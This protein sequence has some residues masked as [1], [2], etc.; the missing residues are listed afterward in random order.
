M[1]F[2]TRDF[3]KPQKQTLDS[4]PFANLAEEVQPVWQD[5]KARQLVIDSW[6]ETYGIKHKAWVYPQ[7]LA[8]VKDW[9]VV[10]NETGLI[11]AKNLL[12][13]SVKHN[14]EHQGIYCFLMSN[15]RYLTKQASVEGLPYCA[16]VPLILA[17]FK[18]YAAIPYSQWDRNEVSMVINPSLYEAATL[19]P[20]HFSREE[21]LE[22]RAEG[23]RVKTGP[24]A[25]TQR[26]PITT[27]GLHGLPWEL[28]DGRA[29]MGQLPQLTRMMLCQTW[30]AHPSLRNEYMI[31][32]PDN[33]DELPDPLVSEHW[34]V[35]HAKTYEKPDLPVMKLPWD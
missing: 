28:A 7:I 29:G 24:K 19:K 34:E 3:S 15:H 14:P 18:K 23:L 16:F 32:D 6:S 1:P 9:S 26:S 27:Y 4:L 5:E 22:L 17:A 30:C 35:P 12:K 11:S 10:R 2:Y 33:W 13:T 8:R 31:L 20:P 25:N 21:L